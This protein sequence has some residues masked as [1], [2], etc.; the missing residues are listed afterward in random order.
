MKKCAVP[1][2]TEVISAD[3]AVISH[4]PSQNSLNILNNYDVEIPFGTVI[5]CVRY[6]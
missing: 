2:A 3:V 1:V 6:A 4:T 5:G